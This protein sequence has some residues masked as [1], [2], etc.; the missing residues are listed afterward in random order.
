MGLGGK[1]SSHLV[2]FLIGAALP[3]A[4]LFFLASDRLGDGLSSIFMSWGSSGTRQ[5][6]GPRAQESDNTTAHDQ[7]VYIYIYV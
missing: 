2:S 3:T 5:S 7:E 4:F 6:A 1:D